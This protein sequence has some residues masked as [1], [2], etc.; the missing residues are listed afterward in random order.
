MLL[1]CVGEQARDAAT[2]DGLMLLSGFS[3]FQLPLI[4]AANAAK[5]SDKSLIL[6]VVD[7]L[8]RERLSVQS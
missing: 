5:L 8:V 7:P 2:W 1:T 3:P 4:I 6:L